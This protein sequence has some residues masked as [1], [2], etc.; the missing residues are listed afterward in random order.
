[1]AIQLRL[2]EPTLQLL[3]YQQSKQPSLFASK[4]LR[5]DFLMKIVNYFST[6]QTMKS[7]DKVYHSNVG[8]ICYHFMQEKTPYLSLSTRFRH[9]DTA[10][11][12]QILDA[13]TFSPQT[14]LLLQFSKHLGILLDAILSPTHHNYSITKAC[15]IMC[16]I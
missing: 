7:L 1:M 8:D 6:N 2:H 16:L 14:P 15:H 5:N 9:V 13:W 4:M 10:E 12:S 11:I 3:L